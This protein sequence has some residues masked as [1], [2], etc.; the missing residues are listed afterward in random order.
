MAHF[1]LHSLYS[2]E[3]VALVNSIQSFE[4]GHADSTYFGKQNGIT[5]THIQLRNEY[6]DITQIQ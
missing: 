1:E 6:D 4:V 2:V 5:N 3:L